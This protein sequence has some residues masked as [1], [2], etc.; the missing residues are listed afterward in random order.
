LRHRGEGEPAKPADPV[1]SAEI[2]AQP[3][4]AKESDAPAPRGVAPRWSLD[5]DPEGPLRL[6]GQVLGPDGKAVAGAEVWLGSVPPRDTKT[7]ED[8]TFSFEKL[9]GRTYAISAASGELL[10]GPVMYKLTEKSDPVVIRI[11]EAAAVVVT[12][13]DDA[14]Q[15][16]VAEVALTALSDRKVKTDDKGVAKVSPVAPAGSG[17]RAAAGMCARQ[18]RDHTMPPDAAAITSRRTPSPAC[19]SPRSTPTC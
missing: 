19:R 5:P 11:A 8:G 16:V 15:P 2:K 9:N 14:K 13:T 12:V 10:G 7:E 1:R 3:A 6:E 17:D 18:P 4:A